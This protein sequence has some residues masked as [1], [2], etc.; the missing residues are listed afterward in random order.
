MGETQKEPVEASLQGRCPSR[1]GD[2]C[3]KARPSFAAE[4]SAAVWFRSQISSS[5]PLEALLEPFDVQHPLPPGSSSPPELQQGLFSLL[6]SLRWY[7]WALSQQL[8]TVAELVPRTGVQA[9]RPGHPVLVLRQFLSSTGG[10]GGTHL[11]VYTCRSVAS[12]LS[13]T[14]SAAL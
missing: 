7:E 11:R 2:P 1:F 13:A 9:T 8:L 4:G 14:A 5:N 6:R 12:C 10:E 3:N